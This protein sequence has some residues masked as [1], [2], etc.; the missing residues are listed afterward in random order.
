MSAKGDMLWQ[1]TQEEVSHGQAV[2]SGNFLSDEPGNEVIILCSGH[3]GDFMT[4]RGSDGATLAHFQHRTVYR[5]YP[6]MPAKVRWSADGSDCL[7]IPV[8]RALVDGRGN[9]VQ[10][11]DEYDREVQQTL[12]AGPRLGA[13]PAQAF[14][15]DLCGDARDEL[16]LY[17]PYDGQAIYIFTQEDNAKAKPY[18]AAPDT[19][20]MRTYF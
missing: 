17:Q 9:V 4:C 16:V 12:H 8:D 6:D 10:A 1:K 7:W 3:V 18:R 2:W 15:V 20:N 14:A 13:L 5:A 11:L 19:Y